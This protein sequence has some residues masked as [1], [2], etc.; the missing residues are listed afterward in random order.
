MQKLPR[1]CTYCILNSSVTQAFHVFLFE[2]YP[3]RKIGRRS[4]RCSAK[5]ARNHPGLSPFI[6]SGKVPLM[7]AIAAVLT[8]DAIGKA[9][10]ISRLEKGEIASSPVRFLQGNRTGFCSVKTIGR[11]IGTAFA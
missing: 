1:Q 6:T 3:A 4:C 2:N 8:A 10:I 11:R 7:I 5:P 9:K